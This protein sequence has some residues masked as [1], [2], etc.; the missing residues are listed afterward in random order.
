MPPVD[1]GKQP[2]QKCSAPTGVTW[3]TN[4]V[5]PGE[6]PGGMQMGGHVWSPGSQKVAHV[7][8]WPMTPVGYAGM[9]SGASPQSS[10]ST[11]QVGL[12]FICAWEDEATRTNNR[13]PE[14]S[15]I[16]RFMGDSSCQ[17]GRG[18]TVVEAAGGGAGWAGGSTRPHREEK[19][20]GL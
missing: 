16:H 14:Q 3:C 1:V 11:R 10:R 5:G 15:E 20:G 9:H 19:R 7:G 8:K 18:G 12:W 13:A 2:N 4:P 6:V 17:R